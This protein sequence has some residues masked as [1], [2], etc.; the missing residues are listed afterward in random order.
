MSLLQ[1]KIRAER[2]RIESSDVGQ[3]HKEA[4]S[5]MLIAAYHASNGADDKIQALAEA[6]TAQAICIARD[7]VHRREDIAS[8]IAAALE[9][10]RGT[11][12]LS[13]RVAASDWAAK[14]SAWCVAMR[15]L[16]WPVAAA[17]MVL[18]FSPQ[19]PAIFRAVAEAIT[20]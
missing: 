19:A 14:V 12:V 5:D 16:A 18:G 7:A 13:A 1:E 20:R 15:P 8:I 11:C 10:H 2:E 6:V 4:L 9:E 3:G 17:V